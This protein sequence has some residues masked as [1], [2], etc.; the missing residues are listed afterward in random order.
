MIRRISS[1]TVLLALGYCLTCRL[2]SGSP[3][4][5][6]GDVVIA[7]DTDAPSGSSSS[8]GSGNENVTKAI[9]GSLATKYLNFGQAGAGF[10]VTPGGSANV[11]SFRIAT[12]GDAVERDPS[13]Y[14]LWGTN[15][16]IASAN[17]SLGIAEPWTFIAE[18]NLSLPAA[19]NTFGSVVGVTNAGSY[20]SYKMIFP[21]VKNSPC[22]AN[23][24]QIDEVEF[25][26]STDGSGSNILNS[27]AP[28]FDPILA[29]DFDPNS[30][31]PAAEGPSNLVDQL[32][33]TKYLNFGKLNS[34]FIVTPA[35]GPSIIQTFQMTTAND[36]PSRDPA[37]WQLY[38]TNDPIVSRKNSQ[39]TGESWTL[40]SSGSVDLPLDRLTAGPFV[41]IANGTPYASYKMVFPT[42][43]D[44]FAGD[45]DS[46]Q[47]GDIQF[48][49]ESIPEPG[50]AVLWAVA[51][52]FGLAP[53]RGW[54]H[55]RE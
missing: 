12:G 28:D 21:T 14:E 31:F 45:A 51:C 41:Q 16:A 40:I 27:N 6:V 25:F 10:I 18:G 19:R 30:R 46:M 53:A 4:L 20:T 49:T 32:P 11:Q 3:I 39:G 34:G 33:G 9:D 43:R 50:S 26:L 13:S 29:I 2:A 24:M 22:C 8:P 52:L 17:H 55:C 35:S 36:S 7:I 44:A 1:M 23:S 5:S 15:S 47:L 54:G 38:G 37:S 48:Y 42:I